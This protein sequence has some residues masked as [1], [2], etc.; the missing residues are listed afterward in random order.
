MLVFL[1]GVPTA[2]PSSGNEPQNWWHVESSA[3]GPGLIKTW[4]FL[5]LSIASTGWFCR[6]HNTCTHVLYV[7]FGIWC[8]TLVLRSIS[9]A[10]FSTIS[11][12]YG[13]HHSV[14]CFFLVSPVF[15][16][17]F[18]I[19]P[20]FTPQL[21]LLSRTLQIRFSNLRILVEGMVKSPN[22]PIAPQK[23]PKWWVK[24]PF[25]ISCWLGAWMV[26]IVYIC[27]G[28]K[29][30]CTKNGGWSSIHSWGIYMPM[31]KIPIVG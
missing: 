20:G 9:H 29:C 31:I 28:Q 22:I 2:N 21:T 19:L 5:S 6:P 10:F 17:C 12:K 16:L 15:C 25:L 7:L 1:G 27:H 8:V 13:I 4:D 24:S 30:V 18:F 3:M 26:F 14:S 11:A 23:T